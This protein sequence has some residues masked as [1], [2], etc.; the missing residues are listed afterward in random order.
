VEI[1]TW[2]LISAIPVA[3]LVILVILMNRW[4]E[5]HDRMGGSS[6]DILSTNGSPRRPDVYHD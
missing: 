3:G 5:K 4:G 1:L 6:K 2:F